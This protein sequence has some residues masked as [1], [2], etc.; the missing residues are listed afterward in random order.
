VPVRGL[1]GYEQQLQAIH[2]NLFDVSGKYVTA[3]VDL[4]PRPLVLVAGAN[5]LAGLTAAQRSVLRDAAREVFRTS[6]EQPSAEDAS[7]T[8][9]ICR[10]RMRQVTATP[11]QLD[12]LRAAV[13]PIYRALETDPETRDAT[14]RIESLKSAS[15][16]PAARMLPCSALTGGSAADRE[17]PVDGSYMVAVSASALRDAERIPEM[18]G[19]WRVVLDRGRFRLT[20]R[21][22]AAEWTADGTVR[23]EGDR[24]TWT[25]SDA[26]DFGPHGA[27][28][29][30]PL[31]AGETVHFRWRRN[32]TQLDLRSL[33]SRPAIPALG[34]RPLRRTGDAPG[35]QPLVDPSPL[36]GTWTTTTTARDVAAH[37]DDV[38]GI[39][40]NTGPM[41]LTIGRSRCSWA[42]QAP[43]GRHFARGSCRFA[44]DTLELHWSIAEAH[45]ASAPYFFEWSVFHDRLTLRNSPG[46]SPEW[47]YHAWKRRS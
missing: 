35:Q 6:L 17:T 26:L 14:V 32:G 8:A 36:F 4:W 12:R 5:A 21:S 43:D 41:T 40:G 3:N 22:N 25:V 16:A 33:D 28:D 39:A 19:T 37:H 38:N 20:Q 29:G 30:I 45:T 46:F 1:D 47:T 9:D 24:M 23:V 34:I 2:G 10:T 13:A 27:P 7:A 18:Y 11:R 15:G 42:Q 31:G 44:G